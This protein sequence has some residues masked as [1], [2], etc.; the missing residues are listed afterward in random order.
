MGTILDH[1]KERLSGYLCECSV[2]NYHNIDL[3]T[4]ASNNKSNLN[5]T[6]LRLKS[7]GHSK[8]VITVGAKGRSQHSATEIHIFKGLNKNINAIRYDRDAIAINIDIDI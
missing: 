8:V 4:V 6:L 3:R 5:K 7:E 1:Y 2:W